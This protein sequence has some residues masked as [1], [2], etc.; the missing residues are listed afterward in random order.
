M[1]KKYR[2]YF[3]LFITLVVGISVYAVFL[4]SIKGNLQQR[5]QKAYALEIQKKVS[6]LIFLKQKA[7]VAIALSVA[8]DNHLAQKVA[9]ND[10]TAG[11]YKN[12]IQQFKKHTLY[13]NIWIQLLDKNG[14][15]LY[16]S[17]SEQRGD[18]IAT[19]RDDIA[20]VLQKQTITYSLSVGKFDLSIKAM[21]PL[22]Y[23]EQF[24]GIIEVIS[25]FNSIAKGLQKSNI[26]S[27]VVVDKKYKK[28]LA[29]PF[30][31]LFIGDYYIAN[32]NAPKQRVEYLAKHGV[33]KYLTKGYK[34]DSE[35]IIVSTELK[36]VNSQVIGYYI[37]FQKLQ[38]TQNSDVKFFM[39]KWIAVTLV[40]FFSILFIVVL[41]LFFHNKK[42]K[43]YYKNILDTSTNVVV[44]NDTKNIISVNHTFFHYF[45]AYQNLNEF[46]KQHPCICDFFVK[47]EGYLQKDNDGVN[48]VDY[49]VHA[50]KDMTQKVKMDI[51]GK[52]YYFIVSASLISLEL[53]HYSIVLSDITQEEGYRIELELLA[54]TDPLTKIANRRHYNNTL[55]NEI[56]FA[57]RYAKAFSLIMF[58]IDF[59]K[60]INDEYGH[61]VGDKILVT[62]TQFI[63]SHLRKADTFCR[64][65]GEEFAIILPHTRKQNAYEIA[66]KLRSMIEESQEILPITMSFGVVEYRDEESADDIFKRADDALYRAKESGRNRVVLG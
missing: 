32:Y 34:V 51:D 4:Q 21:L 57:K 35:Y 13:Q 14:N 7:T 41:V 19:L 46:K 56:Y 20:S 24:V 2:L 18:K 5:E 33:E 28:Q 42:Q 60:K 23:K 61:D 55:A 49:L 62:Y 63:Q 8:N 52:I 43:K 38:E 45:C 9:E 37:T 10:I 26:D 59:F 22:F 36:G 15:S 58:D 30:T 65:G 64:I 54:I 17:W 48:W 31:K 53:H 12:L 16:R 1:I 29:Y 66:Q 50:S 25:H 11:Y 27:V 40:V 44:I 39:F 3:L 6:E 47:E